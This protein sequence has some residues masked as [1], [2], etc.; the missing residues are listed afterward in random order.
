LP[1]QETASW[2]DGRQGRVSNYEKEQHLADCDSDTYHDP[3]GYRNYDRN[4]L[5]DVEVSYWFL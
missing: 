2:S 3:H 4:D 5:Y 1:K